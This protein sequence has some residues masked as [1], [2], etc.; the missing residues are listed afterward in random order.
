[1]IL[2]KKTISKRQWHEM[3]GFWFY[4]H[5]SKQQC[6]PLIHSCR[7]VRQCEIFYSGS[8]HGSTV[9]RA[10]ISKLK[11]FRFFFPFCESIRIF[12]L[13]STGGYSDVG[14]VWS[15]SMEKQIE[16]NKSCAT[17]PW[18]SFGYGLN[19]MK[20]YNLKV[21]SRYT[22]TRYSHALTLIRAAGVVYDSR[23]FEEV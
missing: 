5:E 18:K 12:Q 4:F 8:D 19:S 17:V 20:C 6:R 16:A 23:Y 10:R 22:D 13:I 7:A 11:G 2:C 15:R 3:F 9:H 21:V 14:P 1:M